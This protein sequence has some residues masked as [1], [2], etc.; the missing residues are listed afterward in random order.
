MQ[1]EILFGDGDG[2][3]RLVKVVLTPEEMKA[4]AEHHH[5]DICA[6]CYALRRCYQQVPDGWYHYSDRIKPIVLN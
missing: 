6:K 1:Y 2:A 4:A 3:T 5:P